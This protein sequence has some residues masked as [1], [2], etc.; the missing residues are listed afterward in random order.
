V[1]PVGK[2][3]VQPSDAVQDVAL[4]EVQ[5]SVDVPPGAMTEGLTTNVAVGM[6]LTSAPAL[7]VPPGPVQDKEYEVGLATGPVL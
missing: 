4:L 3:P 2:V 1:P 6:R 7:E 5:V